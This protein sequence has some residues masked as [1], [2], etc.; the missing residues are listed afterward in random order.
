MRCLRW[1]T[2]SLNCGSNTNS[3]AH[4]DDHVDGHPSAEPAICVWID[5]EQ[6]HAGRLADRRFRVVRA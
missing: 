5:G 6:R 2:A 1:E 4:N 3:A